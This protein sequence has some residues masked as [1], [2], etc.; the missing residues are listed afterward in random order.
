LKGRYGFGNSFS[1]SSHNKM[2]GKYGLPWSDYNN[3]KGEYGFKIGFSGS[4][5]NIRRGD[6]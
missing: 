5:Y 1:G 4:D 6:Y 3:L 2:K